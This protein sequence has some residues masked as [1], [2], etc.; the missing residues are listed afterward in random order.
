[1]HADGKSTDGLHRYSFDVIPLAGCPGRHFPAQSSALLKLITHAAVNVPA[2]AVAQA[3]AS[4]AG[5]MLNNP[6]ALDSRPIS[7]QFEQIPA[8]RAMQL[9]ADIDG[10]KAVFE[11]MQVRFKPK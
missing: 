1:M 7:L 2:R 10:R 3:V 8:G 11:G 6:Q 5:L 4:K 9:I